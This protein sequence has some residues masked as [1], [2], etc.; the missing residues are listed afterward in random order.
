MQWDGTDDAALPSIY[1][2]H[3]AAAQAYGELNDRL[4]KK[5]MGLDRFPFDHAGQVR[6]VVTIKPERFHVYR[7]PA[8]H[9]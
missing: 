8:G 4:A 7:G 2:R 3:V 1:V 6:V 5:Y 9:R